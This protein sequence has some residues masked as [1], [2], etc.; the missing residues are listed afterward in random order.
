MVRPVSACRATFAVKRPD[1]QNLNTACGDRRWSY[2]PFKELRREP[3]H[4]KWKAWCYL[5]PDASVLHA[6]KSCWEL[7]GLREQGTGSLRV[8]DVLPWMSPERWN[9]FLQTLET[10]SPLVLAVHVRTAEGRLQRVLAMAELDERK[11]RT[12]GCHVLLRDCLGVEQGL[13]REDQAWRRQALLEAM[14]E[15][16]LFLRA[17]GSPRK[18]IRPHVVL[19]ANQAFQ[20][21]TGAGRKAVAGL[22]LELV[23]GE[24]GAVLSGRH[25]QA[26]Q[27]GLPGS[28]AWR[29]GETAFQVHVHDVGRNVHALIFRSEPRQGGQALAARTAVVD[30]QEILRHIR[31]ILQ[32]VCS[33]LRGQSRELSPA[34]AEELLHVE[35]RICAMDLAYELFDQISC[36]PGLIDVATL[37]RILAARRL[38]PD[39]RLAGMRLELNLPACPLRSDRLVPLVLLLAELM[40][41]VTSARD[42]RQLSLG[43]VK[44]E[45][46]FSLE[47]LAL[48]GTIPPLAPNALVQ[49]LVSQLK[50]DL[51]FEQPN[52]LVLDMPI[53]HQ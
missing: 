51:R 50:A 8:R 28:F 23:F 29:L 25:A 27:A 52:R 22:S 32:L 31:Q 21:L 49:V 30:R 46:G 5:G 11:G 9:R 12:E 17:I 44:K 19:D 1:M 53:A 16:I 35:R 34:A 6:S 42:L 47:F 37:V 33:L 39:G 14:A 4:F 26:A 40:D 15:P 36:A 2:A 24:A 7:L 13:G 20:R 18:N 45:S 43:L 41:G 38:I 48:P 10:G 3:G